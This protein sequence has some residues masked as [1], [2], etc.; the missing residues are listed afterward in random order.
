MPSR[1]AF[2]QKA[3]GSSAALAAYGL[4]P[5][6]HV[7]GAN[8]RIRIGLIGAGGRGT[9]I[10]K[11]ALKCPNVE[12]VAV[13]DVY[14][15][16]LDE[17]KEHVPTLK[18]YRDF[19]KLLDDKEIDAVLI[20]TPQHLHALNF[21]PAI[22][23]GKEVYQEKTLAF[24]PNHA[25]RMRKAL[26]GS[27]RVVQVGIQSTSSP[28]I[29]QVREYLQ[30]EHIGMITQLH[31]FHYR[32]APYGGWKRPV[33]ADCDLQHVDWK[34]FEGE[35]KEHPFDP[36]RLINWRFFWDY[37]GGNVYENMTHQ[38]GFWYKLLDLKI[39]QKVTMVG[40]NYISPDMQVPDTMDVSMIQREKI[41]FTWNSMF[42][43][44]LMG[45]GYDE[46]LGNKGTILRDESFNVRFVPQEKKAV[47]P[48]LG[49]T[50]GKPPDIVGMNDISVLHM[51]NFF[52]C[53]RSRKE[54]NCPFDLGFRSAI[55]CRMA[56]ESYRQGRTVSWDEQKEEI[57]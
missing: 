43:N 11:A 39:P 25:K 50:P 56:V 41:L 57:V 38:V 15:R 42:G 29:E 16:R 21:V 6:S 52:D 31:T 55:A 33:P 14:T 27:G 48:A 2:M 4:L 53:V 46:V 36:N 1:R 10:F 34:A 7:L 8:D 32:N 30:P 5:S 47:A 19:R 23:A 26:E 37:S 17:L 49:E 28:A 40:A 3:L 24:N 13:A 51:Q 18:T 20:A 44:N 54:T 12:G 22:Q 45:A 35:A 9:Q